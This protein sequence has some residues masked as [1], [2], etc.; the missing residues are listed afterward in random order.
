MYRAVL[1]SGA[2]RLVVSSSTGIEVDSSKKSVLKQGF[3]LHMIFGVKRQ[4]KD[5]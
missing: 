2:Y 3:G 1:Y 5:I 4:A